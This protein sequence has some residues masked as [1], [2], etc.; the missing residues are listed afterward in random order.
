MRREKG[1]EEG[2]T[3]RGEVKGKRRRVKREINNAYMSR[4]HKTK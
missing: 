3:R 4:A 2:E 1:E